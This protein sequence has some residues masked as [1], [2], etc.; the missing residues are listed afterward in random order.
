MRVAD[1]H[2]W[3]AGMGLE[4]LCAGHGMLTQITKS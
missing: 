3:G 2:I 4:I 1:T